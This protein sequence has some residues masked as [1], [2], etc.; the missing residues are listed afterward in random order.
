[1]LELLEGGLVLEVPEPGLPHPDQPQQ[2]VL[3]LLE[4]G[5][6][7]EVPEPGLPHPDQPQQGVLEL[8]WAMSRKEGEQ[9]STGV[10]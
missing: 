7:L 6:V 4:G 2:G 1:M 8:G 9:D 10:L 5:L 3:E